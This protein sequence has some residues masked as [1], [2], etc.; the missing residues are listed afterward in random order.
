[1]L[2]DQTDFS[3]GGSRVNSVFGVLVLFVRNGNVLYHHPNRYETKPDLSSRRSRVLPVS[4]EG[5]GGCSGQ[6]GL[7]RALALLVS[8]VQLSIGKSTYAGPPVLFQLLQGHHSCCCD[9]TEN[10]KEKTPIY[11]LTSILEKASTVLGCPVVMTLT[12]P[13]CHVA[14]L[15]IVENDI[16]FSLLTIH[17]A[18]VLAQCRALYSSASAPVQ[19]SGI[20]CSG[21]C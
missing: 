21:D 5:P 8:L 9:D 6:G 4:G 7:H 3:S 15:S 14:S 19:K 12:L 16:R 10:K 1:M 17:N 2:P 20:L 13:R 11:L 18:G